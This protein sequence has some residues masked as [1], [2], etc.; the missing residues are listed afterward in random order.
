MAHGK[1][2]L[3][4]LSLT[5]EQLADLSR[6]GQ[7]CRVVAVTVAVIHPGYVRSTVTQPLELSW[8]GWPGGELDGAAA[9]AAPRRGSFCKECRFPS[10]SLSSAADVEIN[11]ETAQQGRP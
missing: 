2:L 4:L 7:V 6:S 11:S 10:S 5:M 8:P 9:G 1:E 3:L